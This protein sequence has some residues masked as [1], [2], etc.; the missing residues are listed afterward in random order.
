MKVDLPSTININEEVHPMD[1]ASNA[2]QGT[3]EDRKG[4]HVE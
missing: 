3:K 2:R 1:E 4:V